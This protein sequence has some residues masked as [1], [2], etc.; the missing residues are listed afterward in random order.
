MLLRNKTELLNIEKRQF[1]LAGKIS[2]LEEI[3]KRLED[4]FGI[5]DV[6]YKHI[7]QVDYEKQKPYFTTFSQRYGTINYQIAQ[8]ME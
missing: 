2:K 8:K 1:D 7:G 6:R 3:D 5:I 4:F